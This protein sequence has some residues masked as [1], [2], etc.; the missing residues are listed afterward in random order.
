VQDFIRVVCELFQQT[1]A[2]WRTVFYITGAIYLFGTIVYGIFGSGDVQ[3]WAAD[4][5][6]EEMQELKAIDGVKSKKDHN[7]E[8]KLPAA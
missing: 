4:S 8:T 3:P 7:E 5:K 1:R 6:T 2:A